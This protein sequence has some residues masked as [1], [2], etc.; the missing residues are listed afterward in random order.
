M[1]SP[2]KGVLPRRHVLL[3]Y[4]LATVIGM[5]GL[6]VGVALPHVPALKLVYFASYTVLILISAAAGGFG[7]GMLCTLLCVIGVAYWLEPAGSITI[8]EPAEILATGVFV[9]VGVIVSSISERMHRAVRF[10]REARL[11]AE[12]VAA[13]EQ[14]AK[15]A[16]LAAH[17]AREEMLGVVS[18]DLRDPLAVIEL[19]AGLIERSAGADE[20]VRHRTAILHRTARRMSRLV[21]NLLSSS[22]LAVGELSI[23]PEPE[24]VEALLLQTVEEH[25]P[26]AREKSITLEYE[27]T[28]DLPKVSCDCDRVLQVLSNLVSNALRFTPKGGRV[29]LCADRQ[30]DFVRVR[31]GDTGCGISTGM[32]PHI[33]EPYSR[34]RRQQ[35]GRTGLGLSI[36]KAVIERHGGSIAVESQEGTGTTF[37][38]TLPV[39]TELEGHQE[40]DCAPPDKHVI[41]HAWASAPTAAD[42]R[43]DPLRRY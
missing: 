20:E 6:L 17:R 32:L 35:G 10:E 40:K 25:E 38:F 9:V 1:Q 2:M 23:D 5:V 30:G 21:H 34:E 4:G 28:P 15:E 11:L 19:C 43:G 13:A 39:A 37:S 27:V 41:A 3:R 36:A 22:A 7:P 14:R 8:D 24:P 12:Q 18:H 42:R 26:E 33:F 29:K 31:V 16:I